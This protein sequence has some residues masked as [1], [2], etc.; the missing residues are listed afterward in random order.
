MDNLLGSQRSKKVL[1]LVHLDLIF[2]FPLS[3]VLM[4]VVRYQNVCIYTQYN[5]K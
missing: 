3:S 1:V 2:L 5:N 4:K